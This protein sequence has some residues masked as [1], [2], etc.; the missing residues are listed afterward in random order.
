MTNEKAVSLISD[1]INTAFNWEQLRTFNPFDNCK[2]LMTA[3]RNKARAEEGVEYS[4][5][6]AP[7]LCNKT[8]N[9]ESRRQLL[10]QLIACLDAGGTVSFPSK[11]DRDGDDWWYAPRTNLKKENG[12]V[13][14]WESEDHI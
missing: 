6:A 12:Y 2:E 7:Y 10:L 14:H 5:S 4:F 13:Q 8:P 9:A 3:E 11:L 1:M